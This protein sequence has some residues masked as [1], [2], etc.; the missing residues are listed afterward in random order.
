M[1][2]RRDSDSERFKF[3]IDDRTG[4]QYGFQPKTSE[5]N[6]YS[7]ESGRPLS[8]LGLKVAPSSYDMPPPS[9]KSLGGEGDISGDPRSNSG[10]SSYVDAF[11]IPAESTKNIVY[12]NSS[13]SIN[14]NSDP[15]VYIVGSN[16]TQ[17]MSV[18]PQLIAGQEGQVLALECVGSS[19]TLRSGS[20]LTL[21]LGG[22]FVTLVSGGV[23]TLMYHVT[24]ATTL[25]ADNTWH[26]LSYSLTNGF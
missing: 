18:N 12:V 5:P 19:I 15:I 22:S 2:K 25:K 11:T 10:Q 24:N 8:D 23:A 7:R 14:W 9:K 20:G 3:F 4:F 1:A 13:S 17:T 26:V 21:D 6:S 16:K